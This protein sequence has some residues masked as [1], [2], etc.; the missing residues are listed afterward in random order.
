M[1]C[2]TQGFSDL[3][4][5]ESVQTHIHWVTDAIQPSH[6]LPSPSFLAFKLSQ[7]QGLSSESALHIRWLNY[8]NFSFSISPCGEYSGL[9][10]F[11][12]DWFDLFALQG[13]LKS[14][15]Q[16]YSL[17]AS[18]LQCSAFLLSSSYIHTWLLD[19]WQPCT[20]SC[21]SHSDSLQLH[22]L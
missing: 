21:F 16:Y 10:P 7:H 13:T 20:W 19:T 12:I 9:I 8:W 4:L 18:V 1:D 22:G 17:K 6:P 2:S 3:H 14:L 15:F 5:P 11:R